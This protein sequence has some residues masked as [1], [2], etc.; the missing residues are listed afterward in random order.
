MRVGHVIRAATLLLLGAVSLL[1]QDD[2]RFSAETRLSTIH[3]HVVH[4]K[5]YLTSLKVEDF[6]LLEDG[7]PQRITLFE[8]ALTRRSNPLEIALMFDVSGSVTDAGLLN[9]LVVREKLLDGLPNVKVSVY[10][11]N[12]RLARFTSA[13]RDFAQ[14]SAAFTLL[15]KP[16]PL[17]G[18]KIALQLFPRRDGGNGTTW[19]YESIA[20]AVH[21]ISTKED[22]VTRMLLVFSDGIGTTAAVATDA[23]R[24]CNDAGIPVY[25]ILLGHRDLI[26][27]YQQAAAES[28][29]PSAIDS[30]GF[31]VPG[32]GNKMVLAGNA[33]AFKLKQAETSLHAAE[34]FANLGDLTG[35]SSFDP[36]R[37]TLDVM[38]RIL[39]SITSLI[40]SEYVVGYAPGP[41]EGKTRR[42]QVEIR[43]R[44]PQAGKIL[45]GS[46]AITY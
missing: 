21:D 29:A 27:A 14:L 6:V 34:A 13:T 30:G 20:A 3:F 9:P 23:A 46:R 22:G 11:F 4:G 5:S 16:K 39:E 45:G 8:S 43:L 7:A 15:A 44:N 12:T 18:E 28:G 26:G 17:P 31:A 38:Q 41:P 35:G 33:A 36:P 1:S 19:L 24:V 10:G 2:A 32:E 37:I 40:A 25:A 42:H